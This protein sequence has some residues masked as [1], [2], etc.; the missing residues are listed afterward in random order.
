M[1]G[2]F[3]VA[4]KESPS[5]LVGANYSTKVQYWMPFYEGEGLH[6]AWWR[7]AF[8]GEIYKTNGSNGC[9]NLPSNVAQ[10]IYENI[11]AGVPIV[12][13]YEPGTEP[14]DSTYASDSTTMADNAAAAG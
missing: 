5:T 13:Y 1:T 4:Y 9:L 3:P 11:D 14:A 2:I 6:D 12:I 8:G 10:S 7:T